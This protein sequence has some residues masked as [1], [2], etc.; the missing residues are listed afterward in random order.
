MRLHVET[1]NILRAFCD[2][3]A[4]SVPDYSGRRSGTHMRLQKSR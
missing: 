4:A 3:F 2:A 1:R